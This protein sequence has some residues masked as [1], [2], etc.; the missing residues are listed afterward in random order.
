[1]G[2]PVSIGDA[3]R[4]GRPLRLLSILFGAAA[5]FVGA[6]SLAVAGSKAIRPLPEGAVADY[7]LGGGY[8]PPPGVTVVARDSTDRPAAGLYSICYVNGFQTQPGADWPRDLLVSAKDGRPL[9]DANWPD[10]NLLD[11]GSED[12]RRRIL[13]RLGGILARCA[14]AG[15]DAAEFDNLDSYT[16]SG[17]VLTEADAVRFA[18]LL[19]GAAHA[20]GLAAAQK[21]APDLA[22]IGRQ[23]IGFDF[24]VSE[25]CHRFDECSAYTRVYGDRVINIEYAGDLR[26]P[27]ASVCADPKTPRDTLLRDRALAPPGT[28]GYRYRHC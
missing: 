20:R 6:A 25:Q 15:F 26:D 23:R 22:A 21:N 16:R 1:M 28:P 14:E 27:F 24:A 10:E 8:P 9:A 4:R 19:V 17:G 12:N 11:I 3:A 2:T 7:Q 5:V 13:A 18:S